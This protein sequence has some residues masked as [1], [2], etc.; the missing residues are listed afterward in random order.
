[1]FRRKFL[2]GL[3]TA[4]LSGLL[5]IAGSN[6]I[7]MPKFEP[8][9]PRVSQ[10]DIAA[11]NANPNK[12][13][14]T[15]LIIDP[16][17]KS[18][19]NF[20]KLESKLTHV[21]G[22]LYK[23]K[24]NAAD[25]TSLLDVAGIQFERN[26]PTG[27]LPLPK[28]DETKPQEKIYWDSEVL[29]NDTDQ[30]LRATRYS[31]GIDGTGVLI[32]VIDTGVDSNAVGLTGSKVIHREDFSSPPEDGSCSD[33]GY[34]DPHGH[35]THVA[36]IAAGSDTLLEGVAPGAQ[37]VDLRVLNCEGSGWMSDVDE[38][39]QWLIDNRQS[40][41]VKVVN[42][43]LGTNSGQQN[44]LDSTSI[45]INRLVAMGTFVSVAAGN[46]GT[47]STNLYSPATSEF[48][49]TVAAATVTRLGN[50]L[51][52]YSSHG[53]TSDGRAGIDITAPGSGIRAA[54][55]TKYSGFWQS[56]PETTKAGTSMAAPY[57]AGTAA[58]LLQQHPEY[59][60]SGE[61]CE[62][63]DTCPSGVIK[64]TMV[65]SVLD[66]FK[67]N[68]WFDPGVDSHSGA[69]LISAS[70]SVLGTDLPTAKTIR[71]STDGQSDTIIRF[72]PSN[73]SRVVTFLFDS[74]WLTNAF[75]W[76]QRF[77]I[78]LINHEVERIDVGHPCSLLAWGACLFGDQSR[79]MYNYVLPASETPLYFTISTSA[80][81]QMTINVDSYNGE[82]TSISGIKVSPVDLTSTGSGIMKVTR[83]SDSS[84]STNFNLSA[85]GGVGVPANVL[86]PAGPAGTEVSVQLEAPE[87]NVHT[88]EKVIL[89]TSNDLL[90]YSEVQLP[91]QTQGRIRFPNSVDT[92]LYEE[93]F[94]ADDGTILGGS[95]GAEMRNAS[96]YPNPFVVS[97]GSLTPTPLNFNQTS[98]SMIQTL[99]LSQDGSTGLFGEYPAG[100]GVVPGDDDMFFTYFVT[101]LST[102]ESYKV[103]PSSSYYASWTDQMQSYP[104]FKVDSDGSKVAWS[105]KVGEGDLPWVLAVNS[106]TD[107]A[108]ETIIAHFSNRFDISLQGISNGKILVKALSGNTM[109][110][111][112]YDLAGNYIVLNT[113]GQNPSQASFSKSGAAVGFTDSGSGL[114]CWV[115]G[116]T[117]KITPKESIGSEWYNEVRVADDCSWI[118]TT[119]Y[120]RDQAFLGIWQR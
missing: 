1:M 30:N 90:L 77:N 112:L 42:L 21:S 19:P 80:Q 81:T 85:T 59:L 11:Y 56:N 73:Q 100:S 105:A 12:R 104:E 108:Q 55:S 107:Y 74:S 34:L 51:A 95:G 71:A 31:T 48:A 27:T 35:G 23:G 116:T 97:P 46:G 10:A 68:D 75:D 65:N 25:V 114:Y 3:L 63:S 99:G 20:Q 39:L 62:I 24:L 54:Q 7:S 26:L 14:D 120:F 2:K 36:S 70:A 117:K 94:I 72:D 40:Y 109:E 96:G 57:V 64:E 69:G 113:P 41:P 13:L 76:S 17:G 93:P 82:I 33:N 9:L 22:A 83:T 49:V 61:L 87:N 15:N 32:A 91:E 6:P 60:P 92:G 110:L 89:R 52:P 44:G 118:I 78:G 86:L 45:L 103:G 43:S 106:G 4:C 47:K 38:A 53:P 88:L 37:I 28:P 101:K 115:N 66:H 29:I 84:T 16:L 50:F 119:R 102:M 18:S 98:S 79:L 8:K 58:L 67:A 111:R 5:V